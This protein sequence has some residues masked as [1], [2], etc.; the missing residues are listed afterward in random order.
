MARRPRNVTIRLDDDTAKWAR[1]QAAQQDTSV[2]KMIGEML[3]AKMLQE[4]RYES[5]KRAYL[6][7]EPGVHR[8]EDQ[9]LP[10][11]DELHERDRLR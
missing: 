8:C 11:R 5:A 7:Q 2:S 4:S 9:P 10:S 6:A 3:R 1:V